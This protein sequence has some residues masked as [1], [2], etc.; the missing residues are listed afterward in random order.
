MYLSDSFSIQN[1]KFE[2][3]NHISISIDTNQYNSIK[4]IYSQNNTRTFNADT[5]LDIPIVNGV[6]ELQP[7]ILGNYQ[8]YNESTTTPILSIPCV[9]REFPKNNTAQQMLESLAII[10]TLLNIDSLKHTTNGYKI[11]LDKIWLS[12][13]NK[14]EI[15]AKNIIKA[16]YSRINEANKRYTIE[17][18]GCYTNRG[19]CYIL[20]GD[21][22][23]VNYRNKSEIWYYDSDTNNIEKKFIFIL[24]EKPENYDYLLQTNESTQLYFVQAMIN[25][26]NGK[27]FTLKNN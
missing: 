18:E 23:T 17:K 1:K 13:S 27:I 4:G 3:L 19:I 20:L 15:T 6:L 2:S 16:Y 8:F 22:S 5:T 14:N 24:S 10:D 7:K 9:S 25:W 21:P 26:K 12:Y 11:E